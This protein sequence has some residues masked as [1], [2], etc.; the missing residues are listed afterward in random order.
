MRSVVTLWIAQ[1]KLES[2]NRYL[3]KSIDEATTKAV[4]MQKVCKW[5]NVITSIPDPIKVIFS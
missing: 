3:F 2:T 1:K 5:L 4:L